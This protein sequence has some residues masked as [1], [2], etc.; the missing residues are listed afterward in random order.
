MLRGYALLF[1]LGAV[2][3]LKSLRERRIELVTIYWLLA[4]AT[5]LSLGK[6]GAGQNHFL[7]LIFATSIAAGVAYD[8]LRR[9][10]A[11]DSGLALVLATLA[12]VA[13]ANTPLRINKPI[14]D[15]CDC[16]K[17]YAAM[18]NDWGPRILSDNIGGLVLANKPVY[19]SDPFVYRWLIKSGTMPDTDLRRAISN[20]EFTSI[21]LNHSVEAAET[22]DDRWPESV[23]EAIRQSY[24]LQAVYSCNDAKYLYVPRPANPST[25]AEGAK[26]RSSS[27]SSFANIA[28]N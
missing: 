22:D 27:T 8:W 13:I 5:S 23:R 15:L 12:V 14:D 26:Y 21:V 3:V 10:A 24:Q 20:H 9:N 1:L 4:V 17:V 25:A 18:R 6:I 11:N 7:Q 28:S 16:D 19:V 2:V